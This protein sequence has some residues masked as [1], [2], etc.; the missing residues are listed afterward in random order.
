MPNNNDKQAFIF[1]VFGTVVNW[2][3]SIIAQGETF[4]AK[5]N[6]QTDWEA[7]ADKWRGK[8]QP[9][10]D[11][12]RNEEIPWT[13]LDALHRMALIELLEE[14]DIHNLTVQQIEELLYFCI[15]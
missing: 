1:D 9:F 8:Y 7:F 10:M 13:N 12:V 3:G 15:T 5:Y 6:I 2:R 11:K 4:G 14:L